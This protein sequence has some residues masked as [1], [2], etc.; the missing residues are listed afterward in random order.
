MRY[1]IKNARVTIGTT[2]TGAFAGQKYYMFQADLFVEGNIF[3]NPNRLPRYYTLNEQV[4]KAYLPDPTKGIRNTELSVN[5]LEVYD[6]P[7]ANIPEELKHIANVFPFTKILPRPYGRID[8][9]TKSFVVAANGTTTPITAIT[10][11]GIKCQDNEV[12]GE[13][14]WVEDMDAVINRIIERSYK[15][16]DDSPIAPASS[17]APVMTQEEAVAAQQKIAELQAKLGVQTS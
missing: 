9:N 10:I 2:Q 5:G 17:A 3:A 13:A 12:T 4:A 8:R 16:L 1:L 7:E 6:I 15:P 11:Y 14:H